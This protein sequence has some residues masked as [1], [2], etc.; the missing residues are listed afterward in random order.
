MHHDL[1]KT[2][3][4][5]TLVGAIAL[6]PTGNAQGAY[7]FLILPLVLASP[8]TIGQS[9][10]F[11]TLPL[12]AM[13]LLPSMM[14]ANLYSRHKAFMLLN[15]APINTLTTPST[16]MPTTILCPPAPIPTSAQP[17]SPQYQQRSNTTQ[18]DGTQ[19]AKRQP[20]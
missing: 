20:T 1:T 12:P 11:P 6:G 18:R 16:M 7:Y 9:S 19:H 10:P 14:L 17:R 2:L 8:V 13:R 5:R 15:G 3:Q 4:A